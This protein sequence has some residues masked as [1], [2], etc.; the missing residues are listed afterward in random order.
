M[1]KRYK[2]IG[3]MSGSS[4]DGVDIAF[5]HFEL[6]Q[7]N[8]QNLIIEDWS[9][10]IAETIPF[11][12]KW[13]NRLL[14]LPT[15]NALTF[16]KTHTYLGHFLGEIVNDF[17]K[18]HKV[19]PDLIA[20]HGHTI[21]HNPDKKF[22]AQIGDGGTLAAVTNIPT[23]SN[24]RVQDIALNGEGAPVAPI[25]D[26]MLFSEYDFF[27]N[28]GG[29]ANLSCKAN[30]KYIAFDIG[31]CNQVLNALANEVDLEY[32]E[33]GEIAATGKLNKELLKLL[34]DL[35]YFQRKYP[36]S[37]SNQWVSEKLIREYFSVEESIAN[38]LHTGVEQIA[39]QTAN[40]IQQ[41]MKEERLS[42]KQFKILVTGGGALNGFLVEKLKEKCDQVVNLEWTIPNEEIIQ[43]K[44][45]ILMALMGVLRVEKI[46]NVMKTVTGASRDSIGGMLSL[47]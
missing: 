42:N 33:N 6:G 20:S 41:V 9:L 35:P 24:F 34:N 47:P 14:N 43:F 13:H 10:Q 38:L 32:D 26:K 17:I 37:L 31:G 23:I 16:A 4:L 30:E 22:T 46:P 27:L 40:S 5:C 44:E 2:A 29:I 45:A 15:Q 7:D 21:F 11:P 8:Q 25:V 19:Y 28:L 12:E 18:T 3:L 1:K 39:E 36:K